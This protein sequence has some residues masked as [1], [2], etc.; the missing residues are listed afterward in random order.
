MRNEV[1]TVLG[2]SGFIGRYL[3]RELCRGGYRVRVAV[4]RP[5]LAVDLKV[6]GEPGQ[7]QFVQTNVRNRPSVERA[8]E[9]ADGVVNLVGVLNEEGR[10]TFAST[11][12]RGAATVAEAAAAAG[13]T[14]FVQMSALGADPDAS[15]SYARAKAGGEKAVREAL[16]SAVIIRPSVVFGPEDDFFNKFAQMARF[17]PVL[18]LIGGGKTRM[19]PVYAGD[20]ARAIVGA[21]EDPLAQGRT[22][23]LAGPRV[24]CFRELMETMLAATGQRRFLAPV[25]WPVAGVMGTIGTI[26]GK[27]PF[28]TP[29]IT[30]DQVEL[31]KQDNIAGPDDEAGL[32]ELGVA[33]P[34]TL[35][36][37][38]PTYMRR[39]R[40][41]GA[42]EALALADERA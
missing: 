27:L 10:Q 14:K 2:G 35:E 41:P 26:A 31:L 36:A 21:L 12:N 15:S 20:V 23:T 30:A 8:V 11:M 6:S 37:I 22:F 29:P 32:Q 40:K 19:Q 5:H 13:I 34:E 28:V 1:I 24:Y 7:I 4:R 3:V 39:F 17:S 18:P 38:L 9:G 16:P 25:P 33:H 42:D